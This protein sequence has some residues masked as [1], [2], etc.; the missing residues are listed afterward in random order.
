L[1]SSI[2]NSRE[3]VKIDNYFPHGAIVE[4][5][6]GGPYSP[7]PEVTDSI[8]NNPTLLLLDNSG[9]TVNLSSFSAHIIVLEDNPTVD[10]SG[11]RNTYLTINGSENV[12]LYLGNLVTPTD[13]M[14]VTDNV[15]GKT[16]LFGSGAVL[17]LNTSGTQT[18]VAAAGH[19]GFSL[20]GG[21]IDLKLGSDGNTVYVQSNPAVA[22]TVT[23]LNS[24]DLVNF[25]APLTDYSIV[26]TTDA[27]GNKITEVTVVGVQT[28]TNHESITLNGW[29]VASH[30]SGAAS[31]LYI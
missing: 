19:N 9:D 4:T 28:E 5:D 27:L 12:K 23:G 3:L 25:D 18:V 30:F 8:G 20:Q 15:I 26:K 17:Q 6:T 24:T 10:S 22:A 13:V 7:L 16:T 11:A 14:N 1:L 2:L 29:H 21:T 31:I